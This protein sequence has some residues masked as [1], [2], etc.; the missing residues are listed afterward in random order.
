MI[1]L[2]MVSYATKSHMNV[3]GPARRVVRYCWRKRAKVS[4]VD[5]A[6]MT[7]HLFG[8]LNGKIPFPVDEPRSNV[9]FV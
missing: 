1:S 9:Y 2:R 5:G 4:R 6:E 8:R 7:E 3:R